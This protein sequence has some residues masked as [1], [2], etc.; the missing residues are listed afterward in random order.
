MPAAHMLLDAAHS[1][2]RYVLRD[3]EVVQGYLDQTEEADTW[4]RHALTIALG[5][6]GHAPDPDRVIRDLANFNDARAWAFA[7][8]L[9]DPASAAE[10]I[11]TGDRELRGGAARVTETAA[12]RVEAGHLFSVIG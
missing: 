8:V 10:R 9:A 2:L 12:R 4:T 3:I 11:H 6:L 5:L 7:T 1:V